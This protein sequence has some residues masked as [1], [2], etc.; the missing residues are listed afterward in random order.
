MQALAHFTQLLRFSA[1][2]L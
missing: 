1:F 2:F